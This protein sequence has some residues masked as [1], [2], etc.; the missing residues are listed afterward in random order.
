MLVL[1]RQGLPIYD[2][3][4]VADAEKLFKGGYILSKEEGE[5]PHIIL[6]ASGSEVQLVMEA[7]EILAAESIDARVVS[8]PCWELFLEQSQEYRDQ[9]LSPEV[10]AR[11]AVE[12]GVEIGWHQWVGDGGDIIGINKF[13]A[14]APAKENFKQYGLTVENV[15]ERAKKLIAK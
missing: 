4:K 8:M 7:Q 9:V 13:G 6:M 11:L 10:K 5:T 15:V 3:A 14:S 12:A 2:R 1:T